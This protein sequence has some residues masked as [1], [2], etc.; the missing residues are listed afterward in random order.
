MDSSALDTAPFALNGQPTVKPDYFQQRF[1]ATLGGPLVIPKVVNSPRT[2]F[3]LNYTGN[4][5]RNPYDAYSTVP[6]LA[7][8]AGDLSAFAGTIVDPATGRPFTSNQIPA[9]RQDPTALALLAL[10]PLPN[11][12][13]DR[14]NFHTVTTTTSQL[15]DINLRLRAH[16]RRRAAARTGR[17][18]RLRRTRKRRT[19][20]SG[21]RARGHLEPEHQHPLPALG[22]H[23]LESVSDARRRVDDERVG[24]SGEL[25]VHQSGDDAQPA[26]R[27]QPSA[28]GNA[29]PVREQPER[30]GQ[31]RHPRRGRRS[32]RLGRAEPVVQLVRQR[33]R[34]E[35]VDAHR[36]HAVGRRH[37]REDARQADAALRR[38]LPR[39]PRRQPHGRERARQLRLHGPLHRRRLRRLPAR[40]A[41]AGDRAVRSGL[42]AVPVAL[43]GSVRAGRL[44]R[45]RQGHGERGPALRIFLAAVGGR[46]SPRHARRRARLHGGG[47]GGG[48]RHRSVLG[49]AARH[50]RPSVPRRLRAARRHRVAAEAGTVV[51]TGYGINYNSS[52][53]QSIAQQL[54]GQ[55]PFASPTPCSRRRARSSRSKR[56]CNS[57]SRARR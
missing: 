47:A 56:R 31:R 32:V 18:R 12:S 3:F 45:D 14:Q 48:R 34:H 51:R 1:G 49:P 20:R 17:P 40:A 22:Q 42:R 19:R 29:E 43:L 37:D 24:H 25:L 2:F 50:H 36:S 57:C 11:Q 5:S 15:D 6:T 4:H 16:V 9:G 30:R 52:V 7:E 46:Q 54:A 27:V 21:R 35:S 13:G 53:Y 38:R 55:P 33:A 23:E 39:H 28:H 41:A 10:V 26:V 44:A 8:R